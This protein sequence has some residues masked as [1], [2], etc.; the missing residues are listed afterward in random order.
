M[1]YCI[2]PYRAGEEKYVARAHREVYSAEYH[3]GESFIGYAEQIALSFPARGKSEKEE[4]WVAEAQGRLL[5]CIMLCQS[6]EPDAGQIRL[7]LVDKE[8]RG[9]GVGKALTSAL[10]QRAYD[11]DYKRLVLWTASPLTDAIRQYEKLGFKQTEQAEN[12]EWSLDGELL[13]EIKMELEL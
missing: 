3:W 5:G 1:D 2:R 11:V 8:C 12:T 6:D 13:Y 4:L 9:Q 7:F 10:L